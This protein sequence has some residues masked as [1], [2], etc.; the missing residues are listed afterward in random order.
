VSVGAAD[1]NGDGRADIVTGTG[2]GGGPRVQVFDGA[3]G[4]VRANFYAYAADMRCGVT[5]AAG[6]FGGHDEIV[7]GAGPGGGP[8]VRTFNAHTGALI[9]N[10]F[11]YD[12]NFR[13]GV[14]VG[15]AHTTAG[16]AILVAPGPS[17][18]GF[19]ELYVGSNG[20][21]A[22]QPFPGFT[23]GITTGQGVATLEA[24]FNTVFASPLA[25]HTIGMHPIMSSDT[26]NVYST[27]SG[28]EYTPDIGNNAAVGYVYIPDPI[29]SM[30]PDPPI[31]PD[32]V[33]SD[34]LA[35]T[36]GSTSIDTGCDC[37]TSDSG[38]ADS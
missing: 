8:N 28:Y 37:Y 19:A 23:G 6:Q 14:A 2:F 22:F 34:P 16:N 21:G 29:A 24:P 33:A 5:V 1:V 25:L 4:A 18:G 30:I 31:I 9:D 13:G 26:D 36:S 35:D 12:P 17:V 15:A 38:Y 3:T 10:F 11:A 27:Y 32:I 7:T 20:V